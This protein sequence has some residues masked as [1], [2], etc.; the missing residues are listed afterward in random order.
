M[1][2]NA[3]DGELEPALVLLLCVCTSKL[4]NQMPGT[5]K[6]RGFQ[7]IMP[8]VWH[9]LSKDMQMENFRTVDLAHVP[10]SEPSKLGL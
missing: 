10:R 4:S 6:L 9:G 1:R 5:L 7:L 2:H 8:R 3:K